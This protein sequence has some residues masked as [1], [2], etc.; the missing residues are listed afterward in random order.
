[1]NVIQII[2]DFFGPT[3]EAWSV[4][5]AKVP[6]EKFYFLKPI[7]CTTIALLLI[8]RFFKLLKLLK[9]R[10]MNRNAA[11]YDTTPRRYKKQKKQTNGIPKQE[12]PTD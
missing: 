4:L 2:K 11:Y 3:V 12:P 5:L 9:I 1:M 8:I 7:I 10:K 6:W